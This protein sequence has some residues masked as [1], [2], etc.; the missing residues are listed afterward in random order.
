MLSVILCFQTQNFRIKKKKILSFWNSGC[1]A[2]LQQ[3]PA[4]LP[5]PVLSAF[6]CQVIT[7]SVIRTGDGI[8]RP[9]D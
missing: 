9:Q 7:E 2:S 8:P 3:H 5:N 6:L 4:S 1:M